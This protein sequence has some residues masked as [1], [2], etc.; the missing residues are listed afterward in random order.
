MSLNK[1]DSSNQGKARRSQ[2]PGQLRF[3][4]GILR[5]GDWITSHTNCRLE[6]S[7]LSY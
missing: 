6:V 4:T 3:L 1:S 5:G 7:N 2:G